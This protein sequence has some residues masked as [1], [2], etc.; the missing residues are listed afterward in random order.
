MNTG[1]LLLDFLAH[2][3]RHLTLYL[4]GLAALSVITMALIQSAKILFPVRLV[5]NR[6]ALHRWIARHTGNTRVD[7][8]TR[9]VAREFLLL[10]ADGDVD[11]FYNVDIDDFCAQ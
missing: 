8:A 3:Q 5:F 2:L 9:E 7:A 4:T 1:K 6:R 10:G 11:G